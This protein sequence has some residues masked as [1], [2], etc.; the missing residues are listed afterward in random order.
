MKNIY[1]NYKEKEPCFSSISEAFSYISEGYNAPE[2]TYPA[3]NEQLEEVNLYIAP[4]IYREKVALKKPYV[5][6]I[7]EDAA[8]TILVYG[9]YAFDTMPDGSNRGTFRTATCRIETH[10]VTVRNITIQNDAG[11][12]HTVGQAIALYVDGDRNS[13][14]DCRFIGSQDTLFTAPLP[15]KE[16]QPGGFI[17][18]GQHKPRTMGRQYYKKCFIQGD[19]DFIF[20]GA[21]CYFQE[22]TL[23]SKFPE[24]RPPEAGDVSIFGYVTAASTFEEEP[25][26]YVFESCELTSNCPENSICLGRP[27]REY[28]KTVFLNCRLGAHIL[29]EGWDDWG[30]NH[31]HFYYAEYNS[32]GEGASPATRADYSHQLTDEEAAHYTKEKV[33]QGWMPV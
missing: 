22:C 8:S 33:L 18:P 9:D 2:A 24:K 10:D 23:Y 29:K 28:A 21:C 12:G 25:Y 20:G 11:Y 19:V 30:K 4:G 3:E 26:G 16:A 32:T 7:G 14:Y 27:W 13:F 5:N 1:V 31:S 17:G 6:I 15:R